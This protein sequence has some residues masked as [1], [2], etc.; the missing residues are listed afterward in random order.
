LR[1]TFRDT[2]QEFDV[3]HLKFVDE[4]GVTLAMTRR[5]GRATPG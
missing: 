5:F 1:L 2:V 3:R 4:S